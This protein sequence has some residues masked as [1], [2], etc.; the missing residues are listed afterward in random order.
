MAT[1]SPTADLPAP[2]RTR[3]RILPWIALALLLFLLGAVGYAYYVARS[4]LPQLDGTIPLQ[5]LSAPVRVTR[6]GHGVPT[7]DASTLEDLFYAQGYVAAQDRLWQMDVMRRFAAGEMSEILGPALLEHDR[8]QRILGLREIA[9]KS[10]AALSVRDR[11]YFEA[12]SRGVTAFSASHQDRLP[13]EFGL[14]SYK[15]APWTVE[16]CLLLGARLVQDLNHGTYKSALI[17]EKV[18]AKLGP[19]L[20]ADLYVNTSWRDRSPSAKNRQLQDQARPGASGDTDDDDDEMDSGADSNV[21]GLGPPASSLLSARPVLVPG[22]NNWVVSGEHT[23]TGKPMLSND[24]HLNHQMPNLWYEAHLRAGDYD[25]IGV[26]LPGLPFVIVGHN[27]R[28]TWGFTN[29]GPTVQDLYVETFNNEGA[30]QT[31]KGWQQPEHRTETIRVKGQRDVTVDVVVTRHGPIITDLIPGDN[32]KIALR[33]TAYDSVHDPFFDIDSAQNWDEFRRALASWDSPSQ[34]TVYADVDGHIGYQA[35]GHIPLRAA[36]DGSLPV[37]GADNQHEWTGYIPFDKLPVVFDPPSG[38]VATANA[39][40]TPDK[41]P[42]SISTEWDPPWRTDRIYQ[43]LESGRKFS[44]SDMLSLQ[45]DVYSAFDRFCAE[46]FVYALDH[47]R[48]LPPRAQQARDLMRDWDGRLSADSPAATIESRSQYELRR[49]LLEP[50]LGSAPRNSLPKDAPAPPESFSWKSYRWFSSSIWLENIL[51]KQPKR[52]L[53]ADYQNYESLLAAAVEAAVRS[54][55]APQDLTQWRWGLFSP[56][57]IEHP[58]LGR[59]PLIGPWTGPG[60]HEQSGG[61]LTVK[62]VG[63]AFGPSERYTAD[64]SDF[65]QS[66]LNTVTGQAGNFLSPYYMDQWKAWYEGTTFALPFSKEAVEKAK[67]HELVFEPR[68]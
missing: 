18:L 43:V 14:I 3:P 63:R 64:L 12:Y 32:R 4:A 57:D 67:A 56:I 53:P 54:P 27:R 58:V 60:L 44:A 39:R 55:E 22:S 6:D 36:G 52:W 38:I 5:G 50:K 11:S 23:V 17:R 28:V 31:A 61:G 29:V 49:L 15:P 1:W 65:D 42:Y 35:S 45:T 9:R 16:D 33:W 2:P 62:Q 21:A 24:M 41:Y 40:I 26:T 48:N 37:S 46:R 66:T 34:N 47:V 19:E 13:I 25:V 20:T 7:I 30:Y 59:L 10:A 8:E 68:K 51:E